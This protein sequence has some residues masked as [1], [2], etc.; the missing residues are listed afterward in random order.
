MA[1]A[2]PMR[3]GSVKLGAQEIRSGR[4]RVTV[5]SVEI[6]GSHFIMGLHGTDMSCALR[7]FDFSFGP[8]LK[9]I[10][11]LTGHLLHSTPG[12]GRPAH[13]VPPAFVV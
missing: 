6:S 10:H 5:D 1:G 2:S 3:I 8:A 9:I 13:A 4:R 12:P 7:E 11:F